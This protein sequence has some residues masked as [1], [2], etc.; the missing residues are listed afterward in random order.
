MQYMYMHIFLNI[1]EKSSLSEQ[2]GLG[3]GWVM[4]PIVAYVYQ[5]ESP[6]IRSKLCNTKGVRTARGD[7]ML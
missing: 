2:S 5:T 4:T 1:F 6:A 7:S 3:V